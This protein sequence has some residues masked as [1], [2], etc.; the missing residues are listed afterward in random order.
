MST[1]STTAP[2]I[3]IIGAGIFGTSTAYH[4]SLTHPFP[5]K[6]TVLDRSPFPSHHAASTDINKIVRADYTSRFYMELAYEALETWKN[7][8][9]LQDAEGRRFFHQSGWITLS[10]EG[11][12]LAERIRR[13]F[14]DRGSDVTKDIEID[15]GV[16]GRWNG[17][18]RETDLQA[19]VAGY[20]NPDAGWA[21][22][23]DA[24]AKLME[25]A[26]SRGVN[27]ES[28]D[29]ENLILGDNGIRGA[30]TKDRGIY[31]ADKVLLATGAWTSQLLASI[32]DELDM[33]DE[34]RVEKQVTAAGVCVVHY[35]LSNSEYETLK[36]MPVLIYGDRGEA[37]PP[38]RS[39]HLLK[40]T[41][42][43]S[44]TNTVFTPTG[45]RIS[46]PP[47]REQSVVSE[48][49]KQETLDSIVKKVMPQC[50]ERPVDYWRL[51]WDAITPSQ[52]QL[53]AKH[54]HPRLNNLYFAV[55]GSFHS[56]KFLPI[57]GQ[58]VVNLLNGISNGEEKDQKWGWKTEKHQGRGVHEKVIPKRELKDL[59]DDV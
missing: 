4:L 20:E 32:E 35:K 8:P 37:L 15:Q 11:N 28:A 38:P 3:L 16:R 2:S 17:L 21:D 29:V 47:D 19:I 7:W 33:K 44:F 36:D 27:Y 25:H 24:I 18:L 31:E 40:F 56:W 5:S 42:P 48:K 23:G 26:V 6:I 9:V 55:G 45:H 12:D 46:V 43:N 22:A 34:D 49:L 51:C 54:P 39:N 57:I 14:R 1:S 50:M 52:D 58:Y 41:N 53:L 13:N 59:D 30:K 10:N